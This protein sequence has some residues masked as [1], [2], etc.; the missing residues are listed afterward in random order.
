MIAN[1]INTAIGLYLTYVSI[2]DPPLAGAPVWIVA[3]LG[4]VIAVLAWVSRM[5]D[6]TR[7]QSTTNLTLGILLT[8]GMLLHAAITMDQLIIFWLVLW[9]GLTVSSIAL[10]AALY[11][12]KHLEEAIRT[13]RL[14]DAPRTTN[15]TV[16]KVGPAH[17]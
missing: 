14:S 3:G 8:V 12:P 9:V 17:H 2:F 7:W 6:A 5:T 1:L 4:I 16:A 13:G 15:P 10:W 11:R